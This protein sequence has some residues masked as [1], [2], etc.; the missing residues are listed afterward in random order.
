MNCWRQRRGDLVFS[1]LQARAVPAGLLGILLAA[2]PVAADWPAEGVPV[3]QTCS[4][5]YPLVAPDGYGGAFIAWHDSRNGNPEVYVQRVT[6]SGTIAPGWP[7]DGV[8][9]SN[10]LF[11]QRLGAITPDAS[12]GALI[13]WSD[14][15]NVGGGGTGVDIYAQRIL[16]NGTRAPGWPV[17]GAEV[18]RSP[19]RDEFPVVLAD[20]VGG[21][22]VAWED[23]IK[24]DVFLQYL[25]GDGTVTAG[26]PA[27]GLPIC[28][29]PSPQGI[30]QLASDGSGGVLMAWGDLRDG[31]QAV[32]LQ[33]IASGGALATGWPADGI[34]IVLNRTFRG[35]I[36]DTQGGGYVTCVT[37]GPV[38][39]DDLY[40]QR[41]T[42]DG[43]IVGGWPEGG[44]PVCLAP[45]ERNSYRMVPDGA[46]GVLL[47]WADYRDFFDDDIFAL[48]VQPD[49]TRAPG[50]PL[51]GLR[52][53]DNTAL[54]DYPT[55][56]GDGMGGAFLTWVTYTTAVG[57]RIG[58]Q[59]ITPAAGVWPGWPVG[60]SVIPGDVW[61]DSPSIASDG[62]G[63]AIV[64]WQRGNSE[65]RVLRFGPD[66]PVATSVSLVSAEGEP[67]VARLTWFVANGALSSSTIER[68]T[69]TTDWDPLANVIPDGTGRLEYQDRAV[70][71]GT[72]Y[73]YR[74]VYRDGSELVRTNEVWVE[75]PALRFALQRVAPNPSPGAPAITFSLPTGESATLE[76]YDIAGRVMSSLQVGAMGAGTH[77]VRLSG[78]EPLPAGVYTVRL[79]QGAHVA[80]ARAVI[81]R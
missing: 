8:A 57:N 62:F 52:V 67:G 25:A 18:T 22:Y 73:G 33:R 13:V 75:I 4:A 21:A 2:C 5:S 28:V 29:L 35:L 3:C 68:R 77:E 26:W 42:S 12:G 61:T 7:P 78:R 43:G 47:S 65:V 41:F 55:L 34:R 54:D 79:R 37:A 56:A 11:G 81:L 69:E 71:G 6:S 50:W 31:P 48:R 46:G 32:Y 16:A 72:R 66:G 58:V 49:G 64:A 44:V 1:G 53:T 20:E 9:V 39:D 27:N 38:F 70:M 17:E 24:G 40:I 23:F 60:G 15:R 10:H 19:N 30:P 63:G 45:D 76:L 36:A 51:D 80:V 59:H 14:F 74:L